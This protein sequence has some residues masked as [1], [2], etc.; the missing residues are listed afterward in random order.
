MWQNLQFCHGEALKYSMNRLLQNIDI[1]QI[2]DIKKKKI[3]YGIRF[4]CES[5]IKILILSMMGKMLKYLSQ[6]NHPKQHRYVLN[7]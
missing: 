7:T 5:T 4:S 6:N 1:S 2:I 3:E